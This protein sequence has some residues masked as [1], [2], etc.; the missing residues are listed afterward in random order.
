MAAA[1]TPATDLKESNFCRNKLGT[2]QTAY[3]KIFPGD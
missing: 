1:V 2:C 3:L